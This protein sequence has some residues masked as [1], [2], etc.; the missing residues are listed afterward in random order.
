MLN[1]SIV[2]LLILYSKNVATRFIIIK[3]YS[4]CGGLST[5]FA[6]FY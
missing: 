6:N 4:F 5:A 2:G 1:S 3:R